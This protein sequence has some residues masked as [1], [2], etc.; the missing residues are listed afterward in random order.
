MKKVP[1]SSDDNQRR[2]LSR[3]E[4]A[5]EQR[6]EAYQKAKQRRATDPRHLALKE[7]AKA[8]RRAAYEQL[9]QGRTADAALK[10]NKASELRTGEFKQRAVAS[11]ERSK[12]IVQRCRDS[13]LADRSEASSASNVTNPGAAVSSAPGAAEAAEQRTEVLGYSMWAKPSNVLN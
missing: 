2:I 5:K 4:L 7:A 8:Q 3:K 12:Q 9:K 1:I 11:D 6:R 13:E 10:K